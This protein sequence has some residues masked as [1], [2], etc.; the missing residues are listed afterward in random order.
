MYAYGV[1]FNT[2]LRVA[3]LSAK[4]TSSLIEDFINGFIGSGE[5]TDQNGSRKCKQSVFAAVNITYIFP[6][7]CGFGCKYKFSDR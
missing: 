1:S 4:L 2:D 5:E 7:W 3:C 6:Y